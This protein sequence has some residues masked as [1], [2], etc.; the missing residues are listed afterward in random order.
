MNK[1]FAPGCALILYK[2]EF[3]DKLHSI[4]KEKLGDMILLTAC[5]KNHP[6][7]NPGTEVINICPGCDRRYRENYN[8]VSTISLWEILDNSDFFQFPSNGKPLCMT[9]KT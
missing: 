9:W 1:L 4:I 7:L 3:V 2:P 5:C 8:D 6:E